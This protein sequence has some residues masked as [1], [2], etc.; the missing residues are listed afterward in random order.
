MLKSKIIAVEFLKA[1][2]HKLSGKSIDK[3]IQIHLISN[4]VIDLSC[5]GKVWMVEICETFPFVGK[6]G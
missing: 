5:F 3:K 2:F 1:K 6:I 4:F